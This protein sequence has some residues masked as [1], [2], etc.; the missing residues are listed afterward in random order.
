MLT[1]WRDLFFFDDFINFEVRGGFE[2]VSFAI[3][4]SRIAFHV[5]KTDIGLELHRLVAS[6]VLA[7][8]SLVVRKLLSW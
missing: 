2:P 4:P 8:I 6:V 1:S 3:L 7:V 5:K